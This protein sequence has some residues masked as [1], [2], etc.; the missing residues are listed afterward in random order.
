MLTCKELILD[1]L[2]DYLDAA[3]NQ[4]VAAELE[5]HLAVCKPCVAYLNT[6][7]KTRE[8]VGQAGRIEMPEEMRTIRARWSR[9]FTDPTE[10][11]SASA[12]SSFE[13]PSTSLRT[14]TAR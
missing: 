12:T 2:A 14:R 8:L 1:F 7:R 11:P 9:D 4:D 13:S 10:S 6:Y 3:L 5:R